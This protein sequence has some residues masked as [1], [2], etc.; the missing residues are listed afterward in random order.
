REEQTRRDVGFAAP[1]QPCGEKDEHHYDQGPTRPVAQ[2]PLRRRHPS[3]C[4]LKVRLRLHSC[5]TNRAVR[6]ATAVCLLPR[7][8][9]T[10]TCPLPVGPEGA[11]AAQRGT[12]RVRWSWPVVSL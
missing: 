3:S 9:R 7:P 5:S 1:H 10:Q 2:G 12:S 11:C 6:T 4:L 8:R